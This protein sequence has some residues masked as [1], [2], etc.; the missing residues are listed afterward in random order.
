MDY[1][2]SFKTTF[3]SHVFYIYYA[4]VSSSSYPSSWT[5]A[6]LCP[7]LY[8]QYFISVYDRY[9]FTVLDPYLEDVRLLEERST[10]KYT[11]ENYSNLQS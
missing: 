2:L 9:Q 10:T 11:Q 1:T 5:F 4:V 7:N 8:F 3:F 6:T